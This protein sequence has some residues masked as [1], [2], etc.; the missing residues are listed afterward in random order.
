MYKGVCGGRAAVTAV[1]LKLWQ[2][3]AELMLSEA[4]KGAMCLAFAALEFTT[5]NFI[6]VL[7]KGPNPTQSCDELNMLLQCKKKQ[8]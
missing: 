7:S 4:C 1:G 3:P 2:T 5:N 6:A 8:S